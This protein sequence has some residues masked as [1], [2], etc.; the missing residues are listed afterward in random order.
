LKTSRPT[1][2]RASSRRTSEETAVTLRPPRVPLWGLSRAA[3]LDSANEMPVT[4]AD[5]AP[6]RIAEVPNVP[7]PGPRVEPSLVRP[8]TAAQG[9]SIAI[10]SKSMR[11]TDFFH[12]PQPRAVA[13]APLALERRLQHDSGFAPSFRRDLSQPQTA[14][15]PASGF[16]QGP[17][18]EMKSL[19]ED[20]HSEESRQTAKLESEVD[21]KPA[22]R[23]LRQQVHA[24][25]LVPVRDTESRLI[26]AQP[27]RPSEKLSH[28]SVNAPD[29]EA[30]RAAVGMEVQ[31]TRPSK[32][33][34]ETED[35]SAQP[36]RYVA[37]AE[38]EAGSARNLNDTP[39]GNTV[40]IGNVDIQITPL[41]TPPVKQPARP[42][43]STSV[44]VL[45]RGF[46]TAFGLRQT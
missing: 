36:V 30:D 15:S 38:P 35:R 28:P 20:T 7:G 18:P 29:E 39:A 24:H 2:L 6:P 5:A 16:T 45:S 46:V 3:G 27:S 14:R 40:H 10:A 26:S 1:Y 43:V 17:I 4:V 21:R 23:H 8:E 19:R 25:E 11:E 32:P 33:S 22:T 34:S 37:A 13:G 31:V 41:A 44:P 42:S 9:I 12:A